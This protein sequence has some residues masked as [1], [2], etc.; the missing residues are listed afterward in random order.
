MQVMYTPEQYEALMKLVYLGNWM[1]NGIKTSDE[2]TKKFD[3]IEQRIFQDAEDAGCGSLSE[4]DEPLKKY[5]PT[6]ALEEDTEIIGTQKEYNTEI[7][8]AELVER[9]AQ[10]DFMAQYGMEAIKTM[11]EREQKEKFSEHVKRY[12][13]EFEKNELTNIRIDS[14]L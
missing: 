14:R 5:F 10:R 6:Q 9:L 8:W 1:V 3:A 7:F 2:R 12:V 13:D 11:K 4:Y